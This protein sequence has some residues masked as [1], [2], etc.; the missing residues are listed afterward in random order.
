MVAAEADDRAS[1]TGL[2]LRPRQAADRLRRTAGNLPVD[3]LHAGAPERIPARHCFRASSRSSAPPRRSSRT[4]TPHRRAE[5]HDARAGSLG[6]RDR[7]AAAKAC[8]CATRPAGSTSL[9]DLDS[10][11]RRAARQPA[12]SPRGARCSTRSRS[13]SSSRSPSRSRST[14]AGSSTFVYPL[15]ALALGTL[16]TLAVLYMSE[17]I[18]RE[19]VHD[20]FS[21]FVP[22]DVVDAGGR[23]R[24]RQ[25]AP[26]RRRTRLHG[27]VLRP[28]RLHELLRD[29][30][31]RAA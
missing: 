22:A 18:E 30:A 13:R 14:A 6:Q 3:L 26:R 25:P 4:S 2:D 20:L 21:R 1:D 17:T 19:R 15:L 23:E 12:R 29:A 24:R 16:G 8:R 11:G 28:A 5:R 31:R 9:L 10:R 27:A 7:D